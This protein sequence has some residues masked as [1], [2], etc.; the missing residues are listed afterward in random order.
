M[1]QIGS[2]MTIERTNGRQEEEFGMAQ[3]WGGLADL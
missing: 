2:H 1:K 3:Q